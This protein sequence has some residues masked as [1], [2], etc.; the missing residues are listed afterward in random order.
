[1]RTGGL[2]T[3]SLLGALL[4]FVLTGW[5]LFFTQFHEVFFPPGTWTFDYGSS[6]IRL[7]PDRLWFDGG[8]I[9]VSSALAFGLVATAVGHLLYR[10]LRPAR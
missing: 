3:V 9:L 6:L 5:S 4:F 7:F 8:V 1:M 2:V 10:R